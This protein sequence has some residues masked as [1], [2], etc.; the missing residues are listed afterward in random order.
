MT[1]LIASLVPSI[2]RQAIEV[3]VE[4]IVEVDVVE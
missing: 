4:D 3:R 2:S 1:I